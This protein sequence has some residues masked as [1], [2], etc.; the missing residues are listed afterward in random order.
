[1]AVAAVDPAFP[2]ISRQ[3]IQTALGSRASRVGSVYY[4]V[5]IEG[6]GYEDGKPEFDAVLTP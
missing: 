2:A 5:D 4:D 1:M 3:D 6:L